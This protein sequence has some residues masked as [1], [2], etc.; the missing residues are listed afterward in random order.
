MIKTF[1]LFSLLCA[2]LY[3]HEPIELALAPGQSHLFSDFNQSI[4]QPQF[5]NYSCKLFT[6]SGEAPL[7]VD[8]FKGTGYVSGSPLENLEIT[9]N[10]SPLNY[11]FDLVNTQNQ[12][13]IPGLLFKNQGNSNINLSCWLKRGLDFLIPQ[14]AEI[15]MQD[16]ENDHYPLQ[17]RL[18]TLGT[19]VPLEI[20]TEGNGYI[21][22]A[23]NPRESNHVIVNHLDFVYVVSGSSTTFRIRNNGNADV[24]LL[25]E[26]F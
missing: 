4:L 11:F 10:E 12:E 22:W 7:F 18:F 21:Y 8:V 3:S 15:L 9:L 25:C 24:D 26:Y 2:V 6:S 17:C 13:Y 14:G 1:L 20:S 23:G 5:A 16:P 19:N